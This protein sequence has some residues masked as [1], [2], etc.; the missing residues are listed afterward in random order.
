[1]G[2]LFGML[3]S[4]KVEPRK[5]DPKIVSLIIVCDG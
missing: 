3:V 1:M 2:G 4:S 5:V